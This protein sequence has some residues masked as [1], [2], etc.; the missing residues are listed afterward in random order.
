[1]APADGESTS[2]VPRIMKV[3]RD[4]A[5]YFSGNLSPE[6]RGEV[7]KFMAGC[8]IVARE[9]SKENQENVMDC[10]KQRFTGAAYEQL[11]AENFTSLD[12]LCATVKKTFL[13]HRTLQEIRTDIANCRAKLHESPTLFAGRLKTLLG[14]ANDIIAKEWEAEDTRKILEEECQQ[15][16]SRSFIA[17]VGDPRIQQK[18]MG[19][20]KEKLNK[21]LELTEQ[22][23]GW[24]VSPTSDDFGRAQET[25]TCSFCKGEGHT[26]AHC[27]KRLNTKYCVKCGVY[28]HEQ[29]PECKNTKKGE[30]LVVQSQ[31]CGECGRLGHSSEFCLQNLSTLFCEQCNVRGHR[32]NIFCKDRRAQG[33][34]E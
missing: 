7:N 25:V 2:T 12:N 19:H 16:A 17:G 30:V 26:W 5:P 18:C 21:L 34:N 20:E 8:K 24:L 31:N 11:G 33:Q 1:M 22:I 6:L 10:I 13:K 3:V 4:I 15:L 9:L 28:F 23:Q 29:G 14:E 32:S 27:A